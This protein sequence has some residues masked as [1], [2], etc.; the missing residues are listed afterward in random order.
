MPF[1][2]TVDE[3]LSDHP[4][5]AA[6]A[7]AFR[8]RRAREPSLDVTSRDPSLWRYADTEEIIEVLTLFWTEGRDRERATARLAQTLA[9]SGLGLASRPPSDSPRRTASPRAHPARLGALSD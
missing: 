8:E 3:A 2:F 7:A 9:E 5:F 6:K 4:S 1:H